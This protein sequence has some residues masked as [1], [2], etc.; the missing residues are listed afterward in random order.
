MLDCVMSINDNDTVHGE[1]SEIRGVI[2]DFW[3]TLVYDLPLIEKKRREDRISRLHTVISLSGHVIT[4]K[5][6]SYA[7]D[8]ISSMIRRKARD[9]RGVSVK[10]QI[11]VFNEVL[12]IKV[13]NSILAKEIEAYN[14]AGIIYISP[15]VPGSRR[16]V[17]RLSRRYRLGLISNTERLSGEMI[18]RAY[19]ELL[20]RIRYTYFSDNQGYRKPHKKSFLS[21]L[22]NM[23]LEPEECVMVGDDENKDCISA[24]EI[25]MK[26][27]LF[28]NPIT[29]KSSD[30]SPQITSLLE[31]PAMIQRL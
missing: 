7:Y 29:G 14:K 17:E 26:A 4:R 25:G 21:M 19:P 31:L 5:Q 16:L 10:E 22:N 12:R 1:K 23:N 3:N 20:S 8:G 15:E 13:N 30:Y 27:V 11:R 24:E 9:Q 6:L 18:L 28:A 2:L